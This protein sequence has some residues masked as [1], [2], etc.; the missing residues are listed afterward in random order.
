MEV[1]KIIGLHLEPLFGDD[2]RA[3]RK[4]CAELEKTSPGISYEPMK[5][6]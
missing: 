5:D 4:F 2:H 1:A 3:A 6:E